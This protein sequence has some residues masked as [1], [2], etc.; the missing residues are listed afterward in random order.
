MAMS[1]RLCARKPL[2][3]RHFRDFVRNHG[4]RDLK[5]AQQCRLANFGQKRL[6]MPEK[7][8]KHPIF[9][10]HCRAKWSAWRLNVA[11]LIPA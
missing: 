3:H 4:D 11:T 2:F 5:F 9:A 10:R 1:P 8:L 6:K 7:A